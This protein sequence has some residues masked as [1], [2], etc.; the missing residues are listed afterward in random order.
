MFCASRHIFKRA[1]TSAA[2]VSSSPTSPV[3]PLR[4]SFF[5][6]RALSQSRLFASV[7]DLYYY[8]NSPKYSTSSPNPSD[9]VKIVEVGPR[10]GLQNEKTIVPLETKI[11]LIERLSTTGL[12]VIEAGSFVAPKWVP[13]M[14]DSTS[15]LT[16]L[17]R[18]PP[19]AP[20]DV[21]V[22]YPF[23]VPNLKG[24]ESAL[25]PSNPASEIS[26][27]ASASEGFSQKNLNCS[28]DESFK[29]FAPVVQQ[30]LA[31]GVK[32][33]GYVSMV[34]AC[35]YSG[36]TPPEKVVEVTKRLLDMGC[37]EVSLGD[38]TGV[39]NPYSIDVLMKALVDAGVPVEK[40]AC[41]FHDTYGQAIVNCMVGLANGVRVFDSSV[42]GLGGCPYAK[43][44]TGN[45]ATED[46]VYFL[47]SVG[48]TT[49]VD[50]E[51]VSE[52]GAWISKA[53]GRKNNS[54]VGPALLAKRPDEP[55]AS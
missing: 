45:V 18:S 44:A 19:P 11:S 21:S 28:I 24:L 38:T 41:H 40:L 9:F 42:A 20:K 46:L 15:I 5:S 35:P 53:I 12:R 30:A 39:G 48:M 3:F 32:V 14:A 52:V 1:A 27:F 6:P 55:N 13:Q 36:E 8:N 16:H 33:R 34:I 10:D 17:S 4:P 29:R 50:L 37:Y 43:G 2:A 7:K 47:H 31:S 49:G 22:S 26:I 23:L 51:K 25:T 54:K